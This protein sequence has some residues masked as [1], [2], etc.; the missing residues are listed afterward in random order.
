MGY[1]TRLRRKRT[2][3]KQASGISR[4]AAA[5]CKKEGIDPAAIVGTGRGGQ[6]TVKDVK[7]EVEHRWAEISV[8]DEEE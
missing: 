2:Q 3:Q 8:S 1:I 7:K 6:I 4:N 5:L